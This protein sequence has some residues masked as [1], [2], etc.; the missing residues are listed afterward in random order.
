M[1]KVNGQI[2]SE[3]GTKITRADEVLFH[4]QPITL[5]SKTFRSF[6]FDVLRLADEQTATEDSSK[7]DGVM[8]LLIQMRMEAR[9]NKDWALSDKIRD[10]LKAIGINLKDGKDGTTYSVD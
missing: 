9:A 5:E 8:Q 3:L 2:V 4:D 10:E 7:L 1:V 6:I